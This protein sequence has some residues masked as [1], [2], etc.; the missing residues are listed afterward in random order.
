VGL[1]RPEWLLK[2][3]LADKRLQIYEP[4]VGNS[5]QE[6]EAVFVSSFGIRHPNTTLQTDAPEDAALFRYQVKESVY[7]FWHYF[8]DSASFD[9]R[10]TQ[11]SISIPLALKSNFTRY[12]NSTDWCQTQTDGLLCNC[13]LDVSLIWELRED[14][15][16]SLDLASLLRESD[17]EGMCTLELAFR[18]DSFVLNRRFLTEN[19]FELLGDT[20]YLSTQKAASVAQLGLTGLW[21][22]VPGLHKPPGT[23]GLTDL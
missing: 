14:Q 11:D 17:T 2:V 23:S 12:L 13:T 6:K 10:L 18:G 9:A 22:L 3:S 21:E 5:G 16:Y 1:R 19:E 20:F 15:L 4:L 7:K 8:N